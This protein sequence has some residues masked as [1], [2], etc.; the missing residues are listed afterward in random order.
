[1]HL[2]LHNTFEH[3][4]EILP[5]LYRQIHAFSVEEKKTFRK[6]LTT[7]RGRKG[8]SDKVGLFE[9]FADK[10]MTPEVITLAVFRAR[11]GNQKTKDDF[12]SSQKELLEELLDFIIRKDPYAQN[13]LFE[14]EIARADKLVQ[15]REFDLAYFQLEYINKQLAFHDHPY[16]SG[17]V[18]RK[19]QMLIQFVK[20]K[21]WK[22]DFTSLIN[23]EMMLANDA[24]TRTKAYHLQL[25]VGMRMSRS[26][27]IKT[28]EDQTEF[29]HEISEYEVGS[30][31]SDISFNT[32]IYISKA[33][34]RVFKMLNDY[35]SAF[36]L[37]IKLV[38][39]LEEQSSLLL[40][41]KPV[42]LFTEYL[43]A[44]DLCYR[45]GR[46]NDVETYLIKA[47]H[48]SNSCKDDSA[49]R[50]ILLTHTRCLVY[51][52]Y[53]TNDQL[54]AAATRLHK[55]LEFRISEA[56]EIQLP[57]L[58]STTM[59][60]HLKLGDKRVIDWC[61]GVANGLSGEKR[62]DFIQI[63]QVIR[64]CSLYAICKPR[65][66]MVYVDT[67]PEFQN[68]VLFVKTQLRGAA[69]E[70]P[71]ERAVLQCFLQMC[72]SN[73]IDQHLKLLSTLM[74]SLTNMAAKGFIYQEQ[75]Y[76][77]FD[78]RNWIVEQTE[79]LKCPPNTQKNG[80]PADNQ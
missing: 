48:A 23:A 12:R 52:K 37:Q 42:L 66:N 31:D 28:N 3:I 40:K 2:F 34:S 74:K 44:A 77:V 60:C 1:M 25:I 47:E 78:V 39:R 10:K 75:F 38:S 24:K 29:L 49:M 41:Q 43:D 73:R 79:R 68:D 35:E 33:H 7:G 19:M 80:H 56:S 54:S 22:E 11:C 36:Q 13:Q 45:T 8:N 59:K 57:V 58:L 64:L 51:Y 9:L 20:S 46:T 61:Y 21:S 14:R 71:L 27:F 26:W 72:Q 17:L 18:L 6:H 65:D 50:Q 30:V 63:I 32:F 15:L 69:N 16:I 4:L 76:Q 53:G 5:T 70:I 55:A 67:Y 62:R